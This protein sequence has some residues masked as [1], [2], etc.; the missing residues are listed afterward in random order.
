M[1]IMMADLPHIQYH[2]NRSS[3]QE[4]EENRLV[5]SRDIHKK[6][7][8]EGLKGVSGLKLSLKNNVV[9]G[10]ALLQNLEGGK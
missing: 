8:T 7:K 5:I 1:D 6:I 3:S 2:P 4:Q 9:D 10:N